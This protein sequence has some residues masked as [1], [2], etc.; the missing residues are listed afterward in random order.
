[1][2]FTTI[3]LSRRGSI[4]LLG[5]KLI[6]CQVDLIDHGGVDGIEFVGS[7]EAEQGDRPASRQLNSGKGHCCLTYR[8]IDRLYGV[9][10]ALKIISLLANLK[11]E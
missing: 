2:T 1:M 5:L 11:C 6:E 9:F 7:I 3:E 8:E 10:L 4:A